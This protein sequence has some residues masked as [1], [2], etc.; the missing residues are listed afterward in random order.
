[1]ALPCPSEWDVV[2]L[3]KVIFAPNGNGSPDVTVQRDAGLPSAELISIIDN[4]D[5]Q[6]RLGGRWLPLSFVFVDSMV[7]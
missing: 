4:P 6:E 3:R 2:A 5:R 7:G 1:M